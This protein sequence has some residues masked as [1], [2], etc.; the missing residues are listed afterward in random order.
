MSAEQDIRRQA[1]EAWVG[2]YLG[3]AIT[4]EPASSDASFRRYFRFNISRFD[5]GREE[6]P[7]DSLIAMDA[8][9]ATEDCRPFVAV[10]RLLTEAGLYVPRILAED[11][12]RGFLLL[13]DLGR[14]TWLEVLDE[15]N[16][17]PL[18]G[19]AINSLVKM[20]GIQAQDVLPVYDRA[21]LSRELELFREW[22]LKVHLQLELSAAF[23][24]RLDRLF[25]LLIDNAL[26]QPQVFVHRDFMP[27]NLM[28]S[29]PAGEPGIIDFQD[30]VWGP[31]SYDPI[32][33]FKDAFLSWP[34]ERVE[35]W[36]EQYWQQAG[37]AGLP[38]PVSF[39]QFQ[40]DCDLMGAQ[41]HL[42][43]IGIF[44]RIKHRDGK[45]HYLEDVPRFFRYLETVA[46]RH[47]MLEDLGKILA[48]LSELQV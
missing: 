46:A 33:L 4:G 15:I 13:S 11:I 9:P 21:L 41:R 36:L 45:P 42:K 28:L 20:Q 2:D 8:P 3:A 19:Q 39:E 24:A 26:A 35:A 30:A 22:Y 12:E 5:M 7:G 1:L 44:A 29:E 34:E 16:A 48:E 43:V 32:C 18:F 38:V 17:D 23:N 47:P 10:D 25:E 31:I 6:Q 14:Q 27:R 40:Y 37:E